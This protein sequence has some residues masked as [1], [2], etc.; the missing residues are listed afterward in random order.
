MALT[1]DGSELAA[2]NT[3]ANYWERV[4]LIPI[5]AH[6]EFLGQSTAYTRLPEGRRALRYV[7]D[8]E[9]SVSAC[10]IC[11]EQPHGSVATRHTLVKD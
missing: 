6:P 4:G 7:D 8:V 11:E 2:V 3:L 1:E 10:Q 9:I 5:D